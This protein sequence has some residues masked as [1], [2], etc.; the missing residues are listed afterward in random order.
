MGCVFSHIGG[1]TSVLAAQ[2][3][4]LQQTQGNQNNWR[5]HTNAGV[6]WQDADN[7][8]RQAHDEDGHQEG[9]FAT[10]H[11]AQAAKEDG[12]KGTNDETCGERQQRKNKGRTSIQAAEK[13]LSDDRCE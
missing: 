5:S 12:A 4:T 3:Q 8:G 7:E 10:D 1:S 11:V 2:S 6:G 13:L 9:V